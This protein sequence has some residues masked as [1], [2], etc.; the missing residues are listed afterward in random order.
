MR[1]V[2]LAR[3]LFNIGNIGDYIPKDVYKSV[4]E[5]LKWLETMEEMPDVNVGIFQ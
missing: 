2:V 5:V 4:A 1:N 3:Q